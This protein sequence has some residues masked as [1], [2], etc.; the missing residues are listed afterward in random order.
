MQR[1]G[2]F[3][4]AKAMYK[5]L[6]EGERKFLFDLRSLSHIYGA[7]EDSMAR[8]DYEAC[9][10][11]GKAVFVLDEGCTWHVKP[12][13]ALHIVTSIEA[14]AEMLAGVESQE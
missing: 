13:E 12:R 4:L 11:E 3:K 7:N 6:R 10:F 14:G 2:A 1:P 9:K 5:L 8:A